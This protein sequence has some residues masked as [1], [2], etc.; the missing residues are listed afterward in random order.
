MSYLRQIYLLFYLELFRIV[1]NIESKLKQEIVG[2]VTQKLKIMK[3]VLL[4]LAFVAVYGVSMAV[5]ISAPVVT[6]DETATIVVVD[7]DDKDEK[8]DAKK[9]TRAEGCSESKGEAKGKA[10]SD[11]KEKSCTGEKAAKKD[12]SSSCSGKS[13]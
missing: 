2:L 3:K 4:V 5:S 10:C 8:K 7:A 12:C 9:A 13:K 6:V 1:I 11:S